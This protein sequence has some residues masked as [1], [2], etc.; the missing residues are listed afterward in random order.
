MPDVTSDILSPEKA[1]INAAGLL[2][3]REIDLFRLAHRERWGRDIAP[4]QLE[5][6][7][8][9]Y[10]FHQVVPNWL[11]QFSREILSREGRQSVAVRAGARRYQ[12]MP[13]YSRY[14]PLIV[15]SVLAGFFVYIFWLADL[16]YD[17]E[18]TAPVECIYGPGFKVL[19]DLAQKVHGHSP[20]SC[21]TKISPTPQA[22]AQQ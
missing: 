19:S 9:D 17:R 1:V 5:A 15:A 18:P 3:L 20:V 8:A 21:D 16:S 22:P 6:L 13:V 14:G 2:D 7:F 10:M 11:E 4:H 12:Q